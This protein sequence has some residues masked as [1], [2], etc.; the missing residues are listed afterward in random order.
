[1]A[2]KNDPNRTYSEP[3]QVRITAEQLALFKRAADA[4]GR[5]VSN[6][7]RDRLEKAATKELKGG[8]SG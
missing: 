5:S 6:W 7:A 3:F 4:D 8:K 1:M 2:K